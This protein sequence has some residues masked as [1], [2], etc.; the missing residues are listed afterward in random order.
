M[1]ERLYPVRR[2][3]YID[4]KECMLPKCRNILYSIPFQYKILL[5]PVI[6]AARRV[7]AT[8]RDKLKVEL[9]NGEIMCYT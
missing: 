6:P 5:K 3:Y 4:M 1:I 9:E 7:P 8:L 2:V